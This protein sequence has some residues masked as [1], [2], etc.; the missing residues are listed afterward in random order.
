MSKIQ[1][2]TI[3]VTG[4]AGAIGSNLVHRLCQDNHV[5]VIDNLSS[6]HRKW[7]DGLDNVTF[8]E[9][10]IRNDADIEKAFAKTPDYVFHLA[11]HFANQNSVEH[12]EA[13]LNT[14]GLGTLKLL[15]HAHKAQVKRFVYAS[16]SCVYGQQAENEPDETVIGD[17]ETPYA[18]SKLVGEQYTTFFHDYYKLPTVS[19]RIFNC[20]GS[21]ELGGRYR[22]VIPNFFTLALNGQVLPIFGTGQET[23]TFTFI[24]D[25]LDGMI[26]SAVNED[27]VGH[28]FNLGSYNE[29]TI[30]DLAD[31]INEL[32]QNKAGIEYKPA[33]S[34]DKVKK[35]KANIKKAQQI[36]GYEPHVGFKEGLEQ[37]YN[38]FKDL[39][40]DDVQLKSA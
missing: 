2:Q 35:R 6:G 3:L 39:P 14:N 32:T 30:Q 17:L 27:A 1:N 10:D 40:A 34:W 23:R 13:D 16:S 24:S 22:N 20:F 4:G 12:P 25:I 5:V 26:E 18:I 15:Q 29:V 7:I 28:I 11:A 31:C 9:G 19:H 33:R 8:I 38:W 36:L 37:C 21:Y